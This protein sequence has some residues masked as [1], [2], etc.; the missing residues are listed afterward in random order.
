MSDIYD[1]YLTKA[2]DATAMA[3]G[4]ALILQ[5]IACPG[6]ERSIERIKA[7]LSSALHELQSLREVF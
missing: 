2:E 6:A 3:L 4:L 1:R 7:D 5:T